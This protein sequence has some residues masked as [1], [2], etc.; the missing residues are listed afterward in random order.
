M[1]YSSGDDGTIEERERERER[2]SMRAF[3]ELVHHHYP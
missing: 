3:S 1:S 2:E